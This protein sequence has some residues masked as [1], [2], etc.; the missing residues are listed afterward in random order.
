[1]QPNEH[2][3]HDVRNDEGIYDE[4]RQEHLDAVD[5]ML[6]EL[7]MD[8]RFDRVPAAFRII[9]QQQ[10]THLN[11]GDAGL[12]GPRPPTNGFIG[13][14]NANSNQHGSHVLLD[15]DDGMAQHRHG[16]DSED[17]DDDDDRAAFGY[18][19]LDQDGFVPM[20]EDGNDEDGEDWNDARGN[21]FANYSQMDSDNEGGVDSED[22]EGKEDDGQGYDGYLHSRNTDGSL[23]TAVPTIPS[24]VQIDTSELTAEGIDPI[25]EDDLKTISQVMSSFSLPTPEWAKSIP[26]EK[27]LPKI[28]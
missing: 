24:A 22:E 16:N 12:A 13:S 3:N 2:H 6:A 26:E 19:P 7:D 18:I 15:S 1:M 8:E 14:N 5:R 25:T 28:V 9:D 11:D 23:A 27:W 20:E 4:V 10:H 17:E 21:G